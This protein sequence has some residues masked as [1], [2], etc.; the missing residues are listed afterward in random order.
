MNIDFTQD[1]VTLLKEMIGKTNF[2]GQLVE[3]VVELKKKLNGA[4]GQDN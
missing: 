2:S 1:E 3:M 4:S